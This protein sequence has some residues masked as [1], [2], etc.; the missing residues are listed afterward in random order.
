ME[1]SIWTKE[2]RTL[3]VEAYLREGGSIKDYAAA[4]GVRYS[5]FSKWLSR[6]R[7]SQQPVLA[8]SES[9][10][11]DPMFVELVCDKNFNKASDLLAGI[12]MRLP[13]RIILTLPPIAPATLCVLVQELNHADTSH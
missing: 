9:E 13:S 10:T 3:K 4:I 7:L 12:E 2:E 1:K 6:Y 11:A 8:K 5:T